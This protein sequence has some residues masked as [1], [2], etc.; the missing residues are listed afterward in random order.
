MAQPQRLQRRRVH[1]PQVVTDQDHRDGGH[2]GQPHADGVTEGDVGAQDGARRGDDPGIRPPGSRLHLQADHGECRR[3]G[4]KAQR[5][6]T[7]ARAAA[8]ICHPSRVGA[9]SPTFARRSLPASQAAQ[10]A[11]TG[12]MKIMAETALAVAAVQ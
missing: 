9:P 1:V 10:A 2:G 12:A 7:G 8:A 6:R 5:D 11:V 3:E 4:E